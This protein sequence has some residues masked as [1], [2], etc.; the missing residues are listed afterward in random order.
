[1][2]EDLDMYENQYNIAQTCFNVAA[3][4]GGIP[5]NLLITIAPPRF[6]L[7]GCE[8]LWGIVTVFTYKV[9]SPNQLYAIRFIL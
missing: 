7:P 2:K 6:I 1:M 5:S 9:S 8:L 4:I 3:M